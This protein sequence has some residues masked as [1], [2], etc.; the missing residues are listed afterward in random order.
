MSTSALD[1]KWGPSLLSQGKWYVF[2]GKTNLVPTTWKDASNMM[3]ELKKVE[4]MQWAFALPHQRQDLFNKQLEVL[5]KDLAPDWTLL[6]LTL[7]SGIILIVGV[8]STI[9]NQISKL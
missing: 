2:K 3:K 1:L 8:A 4:K 7:T 6:V 9:K 5:T